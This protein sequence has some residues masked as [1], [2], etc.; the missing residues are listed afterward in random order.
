MIAMIEP[1]SKAYL[2]AALSVYFRQLDVRCAEA[3]GLGC[4]RISRWV[5]SRRGARMH[6]CMSGGK[7]GERVVASRG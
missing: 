3:A 6:A 2:N 4:V 7:Q 5:G 1:R